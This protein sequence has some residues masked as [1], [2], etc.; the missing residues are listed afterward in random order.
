MSLIKS[1]FENVIGIK[2][3]FTLEAAATLRR[4][5]TKNTPVEGL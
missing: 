4:V 2:I 3:F 1:Q 5:I